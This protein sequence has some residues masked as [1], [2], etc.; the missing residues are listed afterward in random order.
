MLVLFVKLTNNYPNLF[1]NSGNIK[2]QQIDHLYYKN[3]Y[4]DTSNKFGDTNY[5]K[6]K[7]VLYDKANILSIPTGLY[8]HKIQP[9]SFT[10]SSSYKELI[11]DSY[12]N[13]IISGTNLNN[14]ITDPRSTLLNIGPINGFKK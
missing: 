9:G 3:F 8:G 2:Y 4:T 12:G 1:Q 6:H 14:Y 11:D 10:L 7:R 13:L 5:L